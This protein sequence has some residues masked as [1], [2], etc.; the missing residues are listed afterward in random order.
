MRSAR[1]WRCH[2][3]RLSVLQFEGSESEAVEGALARL[4]PPAVVACYD[5]WMANWA[6]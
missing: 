2:V 4:N 6:E 3:T 5:A 1:A